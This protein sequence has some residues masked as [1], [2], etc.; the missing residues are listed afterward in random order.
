MP[1]QEIAREKAGIFKQGCPAY[2]VAQPA[3]A[4]EALRQKAEAR[5]AP[6]AVV[7]GWDSYRWGRVA[8]QHAVAIPGSSFI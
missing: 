6:L 4:L 2:T 3:D 7:P 8:G 1:L 5:G